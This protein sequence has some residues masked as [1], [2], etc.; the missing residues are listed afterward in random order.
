[1]G[2]LT[3]YTPAKPKNRYADEVQALI[4]AGEGAAYEL[5]AN[6]KPGEVKGSV[7]FIDSEIVA[8]Q[9][10]AREA[11]FTAVQDRAARQEREDGTTRTV[12]TLGPL[13]EVKP[14]EKSD[15]SVDKSAK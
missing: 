9:T 10:A 2:I 8:F 14:R 1:M 11:G 3:N 4:N 12:F 6:T 15:K 5:I 13:R 7:P